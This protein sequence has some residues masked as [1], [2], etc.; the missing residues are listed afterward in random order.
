[1]KVIR[2]CIGA[3]E[4]RGVRSQRFRIPTQSKP[5][6]SRRRQEARCFLGGSRS[7]EHTSELQSQSNLVCRLLLEK[8]NRRC[9]RCTHREIDR[10]ACNR[11]VYGSVAEGLL[12]ALSSDYH[13]RRPLIALVVHSCIFTRIGIS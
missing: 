4:V 6:G 5:V 2:L 10:G 8:K 1:M 12:T 7:E 3:S 13:P 11:R 9:V